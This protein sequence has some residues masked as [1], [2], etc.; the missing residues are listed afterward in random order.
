MHSLYCAV[1]VSASAPARGVL[2]CGGTSGQ[3]DAGESGLVNVAPVPQ[4]PPCACGVVGCGELPEYEPPPG[5]S[6]MRAASCACD[7]RR[8]F[9]VC[10]LHLKLFFQ[11]QTYV[12]V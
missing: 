1:R 7:T 10:I 12:Y 11:K 5:R 6:R 9:T 2:T 4:P 3:P 8:H